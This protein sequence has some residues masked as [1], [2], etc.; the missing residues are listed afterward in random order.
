MG[1]HPKRTHAL[2]PWE[3]SHALILIYIS[4]FAKK[5]QHYFGKKLKNLQTLGSAP[6]PY[7]VPPDAL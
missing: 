2:G 1:G 4:K 6:R 3:H 7:V 5:K